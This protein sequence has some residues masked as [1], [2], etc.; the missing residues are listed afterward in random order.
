MNV[1]AVAD[2]LLQSRLGQI[3]PATGEPWTQD[4]AIALM[5]ARIGWAPH[6][7]NLSKYEQ[8]KAVPRRDTLAKF[9]EFW[10]LYGVGAPDLDATTVEPVDPTIAAMDRQTAAI[11]RQT[12]ASERQTAA[13]DR[14]SEIIGAVLQVLGRMPMAPEHR[15]WQ[16]AMVEAIESR[17]HTLPTPEPLG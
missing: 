10:A 13:I 4:H 14:Q 7:P 6:R 3:D 8:G 2:W 12:A 1:T 11:D 15:A 16:D 9:V 5:H 17:R